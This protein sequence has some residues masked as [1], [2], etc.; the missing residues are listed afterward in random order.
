MK[1][2]E[3]YPG[4]RVEVI[5]DPARNALIV[6]TPH[7]IQTL[8]PFDLLMSGQDRVTTVLREHCAI[9]FDPT[10][11]P[12]PHPNCIMRVDIRQ[13]EPVHGG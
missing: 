1:F 6:T 11:L 8:I 2:V 13:E 7:G 5:K 9:M 10:Q 3:I 12:P 4:W